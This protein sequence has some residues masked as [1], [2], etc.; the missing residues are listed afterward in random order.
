VPPSI[1]AVGLAVGAGTA[2]VAVGWATSVAA[3]QT[4][5]RHGIVNAPNPIVPQHQRPIA[6]LGGVG[7]AAGAVVVLMPVLVWARP[8]DHAKSTA[9][10][11]G[12]GALLFLAVGLID[13]LLTLSARSKL[14][15]QLFAAL[16]PAALGLRGPSGGFAPVGWAVSV[17]WVILVVNAMNV[18]DVCDGLVAGLCVIGL[19]VAGVADPD[20]R[21]LAAVTAGATLGFLALNRPPA[22]IFLGDAG[23]HVLGFLVA[24]LGV[25]DFRTHPTPDAA[26]LAGL[27]A[28]VPLFEVGLLVVARRR[29]QLP[30]WRGSPDHFSLRL[31]ALGCTRFETDGAAWI[32]AALAGLIALAL[33]HLPGPI[34]M[35]A[36]LAVVGAAVLSGRSLLRA[37]RSVER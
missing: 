31:Q 37:D 30:V 4:A 7:I 12:A 32:A 27:I 14:A 2:A 33:T 28:A 18:T 15:L 16:V 23:S 34:G 35:I 21:L 25:T 3:R 17:G 36:V 29:K 8:V 6:Y 26:C 10:A 20:V 1:D 22:S 11:V 13:D 5:L 24:A 9:L 19:A